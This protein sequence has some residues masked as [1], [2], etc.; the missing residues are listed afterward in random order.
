MPNF[1]LISFVLQIKNVRFQFP[2]SGA[3]AKKPRAK[4]KVQENVDVETLAKANQVGI[5][6]KFCS[7][8]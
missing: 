1:S 2:E 7:I 8:K 3:K 4:P 5:Y 6:N